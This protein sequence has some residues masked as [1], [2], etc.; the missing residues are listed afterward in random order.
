M[1]DTEQ[2]E[3]CSYWKR[4]VTGSSERCCRFMLD[5]GR[6]KVMDGDLCLSR[7]TKAV[8]KARPFDVPAPATVTAKI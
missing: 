7:T 1:I 3:G 4:V 8:K 5:T 6:R 2:C